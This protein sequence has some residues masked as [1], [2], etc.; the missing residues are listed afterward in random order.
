MVEGGKRTSPSL[1]S[2]TNLFPERMPGAKCRRDHV[3]TEAKRRADC[4]YL[5]IDQFEPVQGQLSL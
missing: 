4:L 3:Y 1:E 5:V 2:M